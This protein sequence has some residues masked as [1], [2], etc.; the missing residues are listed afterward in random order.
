M[1]MRICGLSVVALVL[2][3]TTIRAEP[4]EVRL[5]DGRNP[6]IGRLEVYYNGTWVK[7]CWPGFTDAAARVVC[8]TLGYGRVGESIRNHSGISSVLKTMF[9]FIATGQRRTSEI[10]L[11]E[12]PTRTMDAMMSRFH[13]SQCGWLDA[14]VL[15]KAVLKSIIMA[16][17]EPFVVI[18]LPRLEQK[19]FALCSDMDMLD[20]LLMTVM[21]TDT[22]MILARFG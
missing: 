16:R 10:A 6:R 8:Y 21:V 12:I 9:L 13:A 1:K 5:V 11:T 18:I 3:F 4:V 2:L 14:Q 17:G 15:E 20:G 19:L 22:L 7:V